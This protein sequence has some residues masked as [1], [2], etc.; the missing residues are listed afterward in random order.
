MDLEGQSATW[1]VC[2]II[3]IV[4]GWWG[5]GTGYVSPSLLFMKWCVC[6]HGLYSVSL[7]T[8]DSNLDASNL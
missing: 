5:S 2:I 1:D 3:I 8:E 7:T 4:I 6:I